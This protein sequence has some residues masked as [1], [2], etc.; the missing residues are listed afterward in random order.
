MAL[1]LSIPRLI[2][3]L[4]D[5]GILAHDRGLVIRTSLLMLAVARSACSRHRQQQLLGARRRECRARSAQA[6]FLKIQTFSFGNLDRQ[7]TGQL[8]VRLTSDT[9]SVQRLMQIT[10]RI[11][12]RAPLLMLGS[13]VLMITTSRMPGVDHAAAAGADLRLD[14]L[15]FGQAR[16]DVPLRPT[17]VDRMN[18]VLQ[19]NIAGMRLVKAFVREP[20]EGSVSIGE[21]S[22]SRAVDECDALHG[23]DAARAHLCVNAGLV[24]VIW[25]GG[26]ERA[27]GSCRWVRSSRSPTTCSPP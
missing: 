26:L 6:L 5:H 21:P 22:L 16:A 12:T 27:A 3:S 4:I 17:A 15:L 14:R 2:Q 19:E 18:T 20:F 9:G 11:G 1:D 10:L 23:L 7:K 24:V 8:M 13:M 25:A